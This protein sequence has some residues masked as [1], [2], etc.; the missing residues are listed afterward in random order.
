MPAAIV[1]TC[2]QGGATAN[3]NLM[4]T[5]QRPTCPQGE[6]SYQ[7]IVV[8]EPFDVADLNPADLSAAFG[9]GFTV[10]GIAC[11]IA[12]PVRAIVRAVRDW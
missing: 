10:V 7:A 2:N 1:W 3:E 4:G 8:S 11:L 9:A 5:V 6:G 12:I